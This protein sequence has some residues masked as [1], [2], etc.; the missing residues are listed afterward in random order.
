M[1]QFRVKGCSDASSVRRAAPRG[2]AAPQP[3]TQAASP[4]SSE[5][6][7][8]SWRPLQ[9]STANPAPRFRHSCIPPVI[10]AQAGIQAISWLTSRP[11]R[12][13]GLP[14]RRSRAVERLK[15]ERTLAIRLDSCLRRN[16][17]RG[18]DGACRLLQRSVRRGQVRSE[19]SPPTQGTSPLRKQ[20]PYAGGQVR[21]ADWGVGPE[22]RA[23]GEAPRRPPAARSPPAWG[24]LSEGQKHRA[25]KPLTLVECQPT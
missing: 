13:D 25:R 2:G 21:A 6:L 18:A 4:R 22:S 23:Q 3:P 12:S 17:G 24:L 1:G 11:W 8:P 20:P 7:P 15:R 5:S 16:D 14:K 19:N 9:K 10:P